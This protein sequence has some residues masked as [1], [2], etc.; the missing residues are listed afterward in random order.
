MDHHYLRLPKHAILNAFTSALSA[1]DLNI[2]AMKKFLNVQQQNAQTKSDIIKAMSAFNS[3]EIHVGWVVDMLSENKLDPNNGLLISL[4]FIPTQGGECAYATWLTASH[5][6]FSIKA[7]VSYG[8]Y[9]LLEIES[10]ED[11]TDKIF[12]S[13]H[14]RGTGKSFGALALEVLHESGLG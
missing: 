14:Q 12:I 3:A 8:A 9:E 6:F 2:K 13:N 7:L 5:R 11:I 10:F 4:D 1:S